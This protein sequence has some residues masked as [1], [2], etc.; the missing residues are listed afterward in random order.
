MNYRYLYR[1]YA[2]QF[3]SKY[4]LKVLR[5]LLLLVFYRPNTARRADLDIFTTKLLG[6]IDQ[7]NMEQKLGVI[8]E[9]KNVDFLGDLFHIF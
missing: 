9:D 6:I 1:M 8:M 5:K 3:V 4:P 2:S 7:I